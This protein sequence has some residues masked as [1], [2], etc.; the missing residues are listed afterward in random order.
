MEKSLEKECKIKMTLDTELK[1]NCDKFGWTPDL[2]KMVIYSKKLT[3][4][5]YVLS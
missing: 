1:K 4:N 2:S 3:A 5:Y